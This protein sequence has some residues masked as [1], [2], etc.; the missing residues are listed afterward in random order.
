MHLSAFVFQKKKFSFEKKCEHDHYKK[1][2]LNKNHFLKSGDEIDR[3]AQQ[4]FTSDEL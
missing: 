2:S 1:K 4:E 3:F